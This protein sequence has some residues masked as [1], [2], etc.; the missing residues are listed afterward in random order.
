MAKYSSLYVIA[1]KRED[2]T[3]G[4]MRT[5]GRIVMVYHTKEEAEKAKN[6]TR[7]FLNPIVVDVGAIVDRNLMFG[8]KGNKLEGWLNISSRMK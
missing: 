2:G 4:V 3:Y 5:C 1:G 7:G 6:D 8:D